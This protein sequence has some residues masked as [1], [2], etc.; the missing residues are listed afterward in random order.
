MRNLP[1]DEI[2]FPREIFPQTKGKSRFMFAGNK[3]AGQ[4]GMQGDCLPGKGRILPFRI[5]ACFFLI[6]G[7]VS[8]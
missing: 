8:T 2:Y 5:A 1:S 6:S 3:T 7:G 4:K